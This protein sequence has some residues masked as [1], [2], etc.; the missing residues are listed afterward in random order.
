MR[1]ENPCAAWMSAVFSETAG[2]SVTYY[3]TEGW[4]F[5]AFVRH[6]EAPAV[7][8]PLFG[9][10]LWRSI[11]ASELFLDVHLVGASCRASVCFLVFAHLRDWHGDPIGDELATGDDPDDRRPIEHGG[12][13]FPAAR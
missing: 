4:G 1:D 13:G 2:T 8:R 11:A 6:A 10:A 3:R 9:G 7:Q 5:E 12:V